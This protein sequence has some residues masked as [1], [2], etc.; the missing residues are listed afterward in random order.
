[1][2]VQKLAV[3][4]YFFDSVHFS[5]RTDSVQYI[6]FCFFYYHK[7]NF[8]L[9]LGVFFITI[10]F[11]VKLRNC[12]IEVQIVWILSSCVTPRPDEVHSTCNC[13][14]AYVHQVSL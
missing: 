9:L 3:S 5:Q 12:H 13:R 2:M 6:L 14:G 4:Q 1:M 10:T 7:F 8:L 11:L